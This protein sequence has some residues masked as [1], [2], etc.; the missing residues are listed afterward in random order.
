MSFPE[1][2]KRFTPTRLFSYVIILQCTWIARPENSKSGRTRYPVIVENS[3][4]FG[5]NSFAFEEVN[6]A[7]YSSFNW[8][9]FLANAGTSSVVGVKR[10]G[11]LP[12]SCAPQASEKVPVFLQ[13]AR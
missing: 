11:V 5:L 1:T 10:L 4:V 7:F 3:L 13:P 12:H 6:C 8:S 9:G 2:D